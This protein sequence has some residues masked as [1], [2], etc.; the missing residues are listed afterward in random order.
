MMYITYTINQL[1]ALFGLQAYCPLL[2]VE[3]VDDTPC[4]CLL[5]R[6]ACAKGGLKDESFIMI[7]EKKVPC[8]ILSSGSW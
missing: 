5:A 8:M 4:I 2:S 7:T 3:D 1:T 6:T